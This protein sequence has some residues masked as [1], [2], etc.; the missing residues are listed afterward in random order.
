M[1][2]TVVIVL[3]VLV[4]LSMVQIVKKLIA[5]SHEREAYNTD[6]EMSEWFGLIRTQC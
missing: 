6:V 4:V 2:T 5:S 3:V 1:K